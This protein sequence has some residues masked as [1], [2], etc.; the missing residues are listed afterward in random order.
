MPT[1]STQK[2]S[3]T[4]ASTL[5]SAERSLLRSLRTPEKI[6]D[7]LDT[8]PFNFETDE[9]TCLSPRR[10]IREQRAHCIE[11]ALVAALAL[12]LQGHPPL[13]LDLTS[14]AHDADHIIVPYTQDGCWGAISKT[15]HAV[16]RYREPIYHT[17]HELVVSYFHEYFDTDGLKTLRSYTRPIPLSR[18]D[19]KGWMTDENHLWY[20]VEYI[21]D[22]PHIDILPKSQLKKLRRADPIEQYGSSFP[23]WT[24]QNSRSTLFPSKPSP[25]K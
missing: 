7:Y 3:S 13:I 2:Q 11:G 18:F 21:M 6:Q 20:L 5:T 8:I 14:A 9:D 16:L 12:R 1:R 24:A 10:V 23:E 15:N 22:L 4:W 25:K 19:H 17:I